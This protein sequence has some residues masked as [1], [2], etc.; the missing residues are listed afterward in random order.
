MTE[1]KAEPKAEGTIKVLIVDDHPI[2]REGLSAIVDSQADM[3]VVGTA[4]DGA[5]A[6]VIFEKTGPD[7]T[8]MDLR[9]PGGMNGPDAIVAI[10]KKR[11]DAGVIV[12]TTFDGDEDVFRAMAAGARGYILKG[13]FPDGIREAIRNVHAGKTLLPPDLAARLA[14]RAVAPGL[15]PREVEVLRLVADGMS[16]KEIGAALFVSEETVKN[17]VKHTFAKLGVSDRTEA[18]LVAL[19]RGILIL[20]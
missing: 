7:V 12:L 17:H 18:V 14:E 9:M 5:E 20:D 8:L 16:N 13:T 6:L 19:Q 3:Q 10:R 11:A 1:V 4:G 2:V 15:T